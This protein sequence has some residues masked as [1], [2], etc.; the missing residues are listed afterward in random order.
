MARRLTPADFEVSDAERRAARVAAEGGQGART[1]GATIGGVAG[2]ALGALGLLAGP[3]APV[4]APVT[5]G[6]GGAL[7]KTVG[8]GIGGAVSQG[9]VDDANEDLTEFERERQE[10]LAEYEPRQEALRALMNER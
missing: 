2:T 6:L 9:D 5:M 7:G 1:A 10:K 3:L 8:E 4:V